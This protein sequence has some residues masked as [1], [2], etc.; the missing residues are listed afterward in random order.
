MR[1]WPSAAIVAALGLVAKG[2]V[3][4]EP[5][6]GA[7][8]IL[9]VGLAFYQW[10]TLGR[11]QRF[12]LPGLVLLTLLMVSVWMGLGVVRNYTYPADS[13]RQTLPLYGAVVRAQGLLIWPILGGVLVITIWTIFRVAHWLAARIS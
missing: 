4:F 2:Y 6:R 12:S 11:R 13:L 5:L 7:L 10:K 9:C 3:L 1:Y 8:A